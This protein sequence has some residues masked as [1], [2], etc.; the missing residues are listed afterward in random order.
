MTL[1][2]IDGSFIS[3]PPANPYLLI[4]N[5]DEHFLDEPQEYGIVAYEVLNCGG[6]P[7]HRVYFKNKAWVVDFVNYEMEGVDD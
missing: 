3:V 2:A 6:V 5:F 1:D 4:D 7:I